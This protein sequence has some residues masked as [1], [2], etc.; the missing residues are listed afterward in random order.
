VL[1]VVMIN[2]VHCFAA[3]S[4]LVTSAVETPTEAVTNERKQIM[5]PRQPLKLTIT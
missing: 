1:V 2:E 3:C 5:K 4:R